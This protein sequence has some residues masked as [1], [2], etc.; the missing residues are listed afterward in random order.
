[1]Q[2]EQAKLPAPPRLIA[3]FVAGF[4]AV[5]NHVTVILIPLLVD[6]FLWLGP[7]LRLTKFLQSWWDLNAASPYL[8]LPAG[9]DLSTIQKDL[10]QFAGQFNLFAA[11]RTFPVGTSS[12]MLGNLPVKTPLG[13]PVFLEAPSI[14][15]VIG[16]TFLILLFGWI[17]GSLYFYTVSRG[18]LNLQ[19]LPLF[20]S[21][22]QAV[23][24]GAFW[25]VAAAAIGFPLM[26]VYAI[27]ATISTTIAQVLIFLFSMVALWVLL[28]VFFSPHGIFTLQQNFMQAIRNSMRISRYT[29]PTSGLFLLFLILLNEGLNFLWRTPPET[30]WWT[31]VGIA[32]HAFVSTALLAASFVYYRDVNV[33]LTAVFEQLKRRPVSAKI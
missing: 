6:L 3:S 4:D 20:Q 5:A 28:P 22:L 24:L 26:I 33:W 11:L 17:L 30:S 21:I 7:H 27:M 14:L 9:T 19:Q 25:I 2:T 8:K 16:W 18:A 1:M 29:L 31:L 15:S 12:L 23:L 10:N 32:G 13:A